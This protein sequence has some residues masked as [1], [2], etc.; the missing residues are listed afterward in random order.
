VRLAPA[1]SIAVGK[2][3]LISQNFFRTNCFPGRTVLFLSW[4]LPG[5]RLDLIFQNIHF[6]VKKTVFR[7]KKSVKKTVFREKKSVKKNGF[8]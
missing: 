7:E 4:L 2:K 1:K 5:S 8:P 3:S 6:S